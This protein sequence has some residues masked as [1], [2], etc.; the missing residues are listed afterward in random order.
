M[1]INLY[2]GL[3]EERRHNTDGLALDKTFCFNVSVKLAD[4]ILSNRTIIEDIMDYGIKQC[5]DM[6][7]NLSITASDQQFLT[8]ASP[9]FGRGGGAKNY[10]FSDFGI[11]EAMRLARGVRGHAPP[12]K[13]FKMVQFGAFWRIF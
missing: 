4:L 8:G 5:L 11:C 6:Q 9:G 7:V 13:F 2:L 1:T 10:F 12:R 3:L